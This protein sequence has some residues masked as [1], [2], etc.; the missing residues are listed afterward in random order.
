MTDNQTANET[1]R[2]VLP[3]CPTGIEGLDEIASGGLPR[4]RTTLISGAAGSGKTLFAT[5]FLV[6]G[7]TQFNEPGVFVSFE[8]RP[9][10]LTQN[11]SS[12]GFDLDALSRQGKITIDH[13]AVERSEILEAGDYDLEGLFIRLEH[14]INRIGAKR[15]VL[16]TIEVLFAGLN[17]Q[18]IL[19]SELRRLFHWLKDKGVT[20]IITGERGDSALT[21]HGLEEYVS[22]CVIVIDHRVLGQ[23]STRRLRIMKYRG[24]AH[25]TNEYPFLI[26]ENGISVLPITSLGLEHPASSEYVSSGVPQLDEML[27]DKGFFKGSSVLVTGTAGTGKT[28]LAAHFAKAACERGDT[29][30]YFAFEE[31]RE[32]IIRNMRSVGIDFRPYIEA[33]SL[34]IESSRP[35]LYGLET[36]LA[37]MYKKIREIQA[38]AVVLDPMSNFLSVGIREDVQAML[39]RMVDFLK[40]QQITALFTHLNRGNDNVETTEFAISSIMDVWILVRDIENN[41]ERNRGIYILKARGMGHSNQIREFLLTDDGV[42]LVDVFRDPSGAVHIG[43]ARKERISQAQAAKGQS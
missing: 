28:T 6:N 31:S 27:G 14:A 2:S 20:A 37:V 38:R 24:S 9:E 36:H 21:R 18:A 33:G 15:V 22:D 1:T 29:C 4:G 13:I 12:L 11:A 19:R 34:Y 23:I 3:K 7:A 39:T 42:E 43:T 30:L 26:D 10:E 8:E 5:E 41:G 17:D 35:T 25:G 32:Q 16:D 40:S